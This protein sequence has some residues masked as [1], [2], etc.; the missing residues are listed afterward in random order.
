MIVEKEK[1]KEKNRKVAIGV[2]VGVVN[3]VSRASMPASSLLPGPAPVT[4]ASLDQCQIKGVNQARTGHSEDS[5]RL[6]A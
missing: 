1:K 6:D 4:S 3:N 5:N 2:P